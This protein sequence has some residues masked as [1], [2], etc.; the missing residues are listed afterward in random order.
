MGTPSTTNTSNIVNWINSIDLSK[1][2]QL[3][4]RVAAMNQ[5]GLALT[6]NY[7]LAETMQA[8]GK[9]IEGSVDSGFKSAM[10]TFIYGG[11]EAGM[12]LGQ[13]AAGGIQVFTSLRNAGEISELQGAT[14]EELANLDKEATT[15]HITPED[16]EN[17]VNSIPLEEQKQG[18]SLRADEFPANGVN[19]NKPAPAKTKEQILS[20]H[21]TDLAALKKKHEKDAA[22]AQIVQYGSQV[23]QLLAQG[24]QANAQVAQMQQQVMNNNYSTA[25]SAGQTANQTLQQIL[26]FDPYAQNVASSRA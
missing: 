5:I 22:F 25:Q 23:G 14:Q 11:A 8:Q 10:S 2:P 17:D 13:A 1:Y 16:P 21:K 3:A 24:A 7:V 4:Q 15:D 6:E 12:G 19:E 18:N 26:Q 20:R 9:F